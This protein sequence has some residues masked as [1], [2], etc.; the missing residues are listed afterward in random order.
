MPRQ[1]LADCTALLTEPEKLRAFAAEH[2]YLHFPQLIPAAGAERLRADL[3]RLAERH[4]WLVRASGRSH[5]RYLGNQTPLIVY[6]IRDSSTQNM[7][8]GARMTVP[9]TWPG[10]RLRARRGGRAR[11]GV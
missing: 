1:P 8:S 9:F 2:G 11:G 4:R 6:S 10:P 5:G 7:L 3:L